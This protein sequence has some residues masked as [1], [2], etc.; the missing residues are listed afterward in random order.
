[1]KKLF[2]FILLSFLQS[3]SDDDTSPVKSID[4]TLKY[5]GFTLIDTYWDDPSDNIEKTN[6]VDEVHSF[7]NIADI[8]VVTPEDNLVARMKEMNGLQMRSILHL[9]EIFFEQIGTNS[10][11]GAQYDLRIDYK[12]RWDRFSEVNNLRGNLNLVQCFYIGEE[13]TWN[14]ISAEEL[15]SATDYAKSTFPSIPIMVIEASP[16]VDKLE[17]S[18][19]VDWLGFDHYFIKDP[20]NDATFQHE[21]ETIK[22]KFTNDDQKLVIIMDT[23]FIDFAHGD[24]GGIELNEMKEVA[25]SYYDLAKSESKTIALIGYFWPSGF[26]VEQSVGARNMPIEVLDE[27]IKIGKEITG[28]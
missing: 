24:F 1:M 16:V 19:S 10:A 23:H 25:D 8:L 3:C 13:P 7:S 6:Y 20:K 27:Y 2:V 28:K 17:V 22:S 11:S 18:N 5:F 15:R 4:S 21:L 26:D 12:E 14:D 9:N